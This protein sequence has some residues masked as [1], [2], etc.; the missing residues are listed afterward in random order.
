PAPKASSSRSTTKS[1]P[2]PDSPPPNPDGSRRL[3]P[4]P[5]SL[6]PALPRLPPIPL[7]FQKIL[8][9]PRMHHSLEKHPHHRPVPQLLEPSI[10]RQHP[11]AHNAKPDPRHTL[12]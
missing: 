10:R 5:Y 8:L 12:R 9:I 7:V 1:W 2:P 11:P 3:L 6:L 4:T